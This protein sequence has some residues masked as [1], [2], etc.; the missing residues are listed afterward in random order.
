V[1]PQAAWASR[2][3]E[4][5]LTEIFFGVITRQAIRRFTF[6]SV[7]DLIDAIRIFIDAY[8]ER[9]QLFAWTKAADHILAKAN[10]Q[11]SQTRDTRYDDLERQLATSPHRSTYNHP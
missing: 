10:R 7:P 3:P 9:C 8:N 2:P 5:R 6:T 11:R 1:G 4:G